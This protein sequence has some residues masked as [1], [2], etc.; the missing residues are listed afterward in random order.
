MYPFAGI[1]EFTPATA[2]NSDTYE[3]T[4]SDVFL[5]DIA[6]DGPDR[7]TLHVV[8]GMAYPQ[9]GY[10]DGGRDNCYS[11]GTSQSGFAVRITP[12]TYPALIQ[13]LQI[14]SCDVSNPDFQC[15]I[16]DDNGTGGRPGTALSPL[17]TTSGAAAYAWTLE[18]FSADSIVI[19]SGDFWAVYIEYGG[20]DLATDMSSPWSGRT[21]LYY[22]DSFYNDNGSYG[23]YMIR[24]VLSDV[25]CAGIAP[26]GLTEVTALV[27][28]N[29]FVQ[30]ASINF[31]LAG[32]ANVSVSIYD[33]GGRLI[34]TVADGRFAPG[35]H[36]VDWDGTDSEG[37]MVGAGIYFYRLASR[38]RVHTGKMS[39]LR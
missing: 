31:S 11:W 12:P 37:S 22:L 29:P 39:L 38:E 19:D 34:K 24:G 21:L 10:D 28:P 5:T 2:P 33:V 18:D 26:D 17:H 6:F 13:G 15:R 35:T 4:V 27:S 7:M 1:D 23:N 3:G 16:W 14:M 20:S 32:S 30:K 9:I 36:S 25:D 8:G